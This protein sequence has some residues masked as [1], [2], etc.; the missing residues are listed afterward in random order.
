M[1]KL[2]AVLLATLLLCG[3][4]AVMASAAPP[5]GPNGTDC[6]GFNTYLGIDEDGGGTYNGGSWSWAH[7]TKTLTNINHS[8]TNCCALSLPEDAT[9]VLNGANTVTSAYNGEGLNTTGLWG[10]G[11]L[12]ITGN[13]SLTVTGGASAGGG[14]YGLTAN[15]GI[16]ISGKANVTAAGGA[17]NV[18][19]CG[20]SAPFT[21]SGGTLTA[22]GNTCAIFHTYLVPEGYTYWVNSAKAAPGGAGTVSDGTFGIDSAYKYAK[23]SAPTTPG[24][25]PSPKTIFSTGRE[26]TFLN[27]FL[28][29][30]CFG[31]IWMWF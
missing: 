23:V 1:K 6:W 4:M 29:V 22:T 9:V 5:N 16:T 15:A 28:F 21:I 20:V 27:W 19:S 10:D 26:A 31:W 13:G 8:T 24:S 30:V 25:D 7:S 2:L 18:E 12:T 17:S 3:G 11:K 14:S